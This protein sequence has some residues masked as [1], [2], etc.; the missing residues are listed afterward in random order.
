[1]FET[2]AKDYNE[3]NTELLEETFIKLFSSTFRKNVLRTGIYNEA[4]FDKAIKD[5]I[6]DL[7]DLKEN[8]D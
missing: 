5:T 2:V 4:V 7:L 3:I 6:S 1:M 8:L